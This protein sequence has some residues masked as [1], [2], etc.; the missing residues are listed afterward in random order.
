MCD[1]ALHK[2]SLPQQP[3][4]TKGWN[5]VVGA[6]VPGGRAHHQRMAPE[7]APPRLGSTSGCQAVLWRLRAL[8]RVLVNTFIMMVMLMKVLMK[9]LIKMTMLREVIFNLREES[10]P[11]P[12]GR[13]S[14]ATRRGCGRNLRGRKFEGA[15]VLNQRLLS[16]AARKV[17]VCTRCKTIHVLR[18]MA[19]PLR[20]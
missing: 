12:C 10:P 1:G 16:N 15:F 18:E 14:L 3:T 20:R 13:P 6:A 8:A 2:D 4:T 9:V 5:R 7:A 17:Y 19:T 11:R